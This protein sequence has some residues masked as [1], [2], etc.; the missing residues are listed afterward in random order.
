MLVIKCFISVQCQ[1]DRVG[2][3]FCEDS[4]KLWFLKETKQ[5]TCFLLM[6]CSVQDSHVLFYLLGTDTNVFLSYK[7]HW[8]TFPCCTNIESSR[9]ISFLFSLLYSSFLVSPHL[10]SFLLFS[11]CFLSALF[12]SHY[13]LYYVDQFFLVLF[14]V[15]FISSHL[16][17]NFLLSFSLVSSQL[18]CHFIIT[19]NP[20]SF[21]STVGVFASLLF[22]F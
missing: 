10:F 20:A 6:G 4:R 12:M 5:V 22:V 8:Q 17:S 14:L 15:F 11:Y 7:R 3:G 21:F 1:L 9:C 2:L 16:F 13:F 19:Q 18:F